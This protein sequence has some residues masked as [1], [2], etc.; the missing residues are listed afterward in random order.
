MPG[1]NFG[2]FSIFG[3]VRIAS[4]AYSSMNG[5]VP[6]IQVDNAPVTEGHIFLCAD[7]RV[8][9]SHTTQTRQPECIRAMMSRASRSLLCLILSAQNEELLLGILK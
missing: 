9:H 1:A 4:G 2:N 5:S 6:L 3:S 8:A 7:T